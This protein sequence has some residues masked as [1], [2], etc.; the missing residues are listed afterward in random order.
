MNYIKKLNSENQDLKDKLNEI[1]EMASEFSKYLSSSKFHGTCE[2][3][4][5][6]WEPKKLLQEIILLTI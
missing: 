3:N 1:N 5:A 2:D 4:V 6:V